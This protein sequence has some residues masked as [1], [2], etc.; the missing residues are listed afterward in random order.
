MNG[1]NKLEFLPFQPSVKF[2][3]KAGGGGYHRGKHLVPHTGKRSMVGYYTRLKRRAR[4][5]HFSLLGPFVS[6]KKISVLKIV[7]GQ[8]PEACQQACELNKEI[9][10]FYVWTRSEPKCQ[11]YSSSAI[12]CSEV[13]GQSYYALNTSG[14]YGNDHSRQS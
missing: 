3:V 4:D 11:H 7:L 10:F 5:K 12:R 8:T 2:A 14:C 13:I 9:C 6:E 1:Q